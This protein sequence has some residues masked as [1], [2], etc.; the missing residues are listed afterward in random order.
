M[1]F[2]YTI[3][4]HEA[5]IREAAANPAKWADAYCARA[6]Q[7]GYGFHSPTMATEWF[8]AAMRAA[9]EAKASDAAKLFDESPDQTD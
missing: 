1:M 3:R 6:R 8:R 9:L 4:D 5:L 7:L 2:D